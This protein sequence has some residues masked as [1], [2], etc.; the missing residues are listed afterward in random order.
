MISHLNTYSKA[1]SP[2]FAEAGEKQP[3]QLIMIL[4]GVDT[5]IGKQLKRSLGKNKPAFTVADPPSYEAND[6]LLLDFNV[7]GVP[8]QPGTCKVKES[9]N[10][11][12][13]KCW[14]GPSSVVRYDLKKV[15]ATR[16][17]IPSTDFDC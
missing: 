5:E 7:I 3:A 6:N 13:T 10:P 11:F 9:V 12:E 2:L 8:Q 17:H 14:E 4:Q 1:P 15:G 16:R